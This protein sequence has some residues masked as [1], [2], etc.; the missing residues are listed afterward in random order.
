MRRHEVACDKSEITSVGIT[1]ILAVDDAS[2]L[3]YSITSPSIY[4]TEQV[5]WEGR[6]VIF[7]TEKQQRSYYLCGSVY[8]MFNFITIIKPAII[9]SIRVVRDGLLFCDPRTIRLICL[10]YKCNDVCRV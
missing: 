7:H 10:S 6:C 8:C 1:T 9:P 2:S 4:E 3:C 5:Q